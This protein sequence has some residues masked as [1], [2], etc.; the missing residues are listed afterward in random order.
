M[1]RRSHSI[2]QAAAPTHRYHPEMNNSTAATPANNRRRRHRHPTA[3]VHVQAPPLQGTLAREIE[4][5]IPRLE[6]ILAD[7]L[8]L[9]TL[10]LCMELQQQQQLMSRSMTRSKLSRWFLDSF[11]RKKPAVFPSHQDI[12]DSTAAAAAAAVASFCSSSSTSPAW[13]SSLQQPILASRRE[14]G[15]DEDLVMLSATPSSTATSFRKT[16]NASAVSSMN[17]R[18]DDGGAAAVAAATNTIVQSMPRATTTISGFLNKLGLSVIKKVTTAFPLPAAEDEAPPANSNNNNDTIA[19]SGRHLAPTAAPAVFLPPMLQPPSEVYSRN[20]YR[21]SNSSSNSSSRRRSVMTLASTVSMESFM[22]V[23]RK[24]PRSSWEDE[25]IWRPRGEEKIIPR[26][27]VQHSKTDMD[28]LRE[29]SVPYIKMGMTRQQKKGNQRQQPQPQQASPSSAS[30]S[31][32]NRRPLHA[33]VKPTTFYDLQQWHQ[34]FHDQQQNPDKL[35]ANLHRVTAALFRIIQLNHQDGFF[36]Y[37]EDAFSGSPMLH[38]RDKLFDIQP[39]TTPEDI[40]DQI[41][42]VFE[43]GEL[44]SEHAILTYIYVERMLRKSGQALCDINWRF[45]V[46]A[47]MLLAVKVWDDCAVYNSDFVQIFPELDIPLV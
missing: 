34:R 37:D 44:T 16:L 14:V 23:Q 47:G 41:A 22:T 28:L 18:C 32:M 39:L 15:R 12:S 19:K 27:P 6:R 38:L 13:S 24:H 2:S 4:N 35:E 11:S 3:T 31:P 1:P 9:Q 5:A 20:K 46:L 26:K 43:C 42:Y 17:M 8:S 10:P 7:E 21:R 40:F 29:Q 33:N 25:E 30:S 36:E 45:I